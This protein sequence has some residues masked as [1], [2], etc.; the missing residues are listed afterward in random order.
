MTPD[1]AAIG[2]RISI[3]DSQGR[4]LSRWGNQDDPTQT[5]ALLAPHDIWVDSRGDIYLAEVSR[6]AQP[7]AGQDATRF[8]SFRKFAR[9]N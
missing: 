5:D 2:G 1:P 4:L 8:P 3:F 9:R 7:A 6:S